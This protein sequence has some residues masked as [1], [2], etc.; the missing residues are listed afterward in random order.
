MKRLSAILV[1]LILA[2]CATSTYQP[3]PNRGE[4]YYRSLQAYTYIDGYYG[5]PYFGPYAGYWYHP[6]W[7]SPMMGNHYS[8]HRPYYC[9]GSPY[10]HPALRTADR[11]RGKKPDSQ[12]PIRRPLYPEPIL[13]IDLEQVVIGP[14]AS[15]AAFKLQGYGSSGMKRRPMSKATKSS[16]SAYGSAKA[17]SSSAYRSPRPVSRTHSPKSSPLKRS[18]ENKY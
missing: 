1:L 6:V 18:S 15:R 7:Y 10:L 12:S 3:W 5:F 16:A 13:P 4:S 2:G 8:W 17:P 9:W 14:D 11:E